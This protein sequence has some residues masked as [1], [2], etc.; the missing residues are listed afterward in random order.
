MRLLKLLLMELVY[1]FLGYLHHKHSPFFKK[2]VWQNGRPSP[3][4]ILV[5]SDATELLANLALFESLKT[6]KGPAPP[7][8]VT[9]R[10]HQ[11]RISRKSIDNDP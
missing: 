9:Q 2:Y 4:L 7:L 3:G 10:S 5:G 11:I 1:T 8:R 6:F